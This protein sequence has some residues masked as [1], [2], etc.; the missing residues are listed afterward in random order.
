MAD[1]PSQ[2]AGAM[3]WTKSKRLGQAIV[4]EISIVNSFKETYRNREDITNLPP[5][6]LVVGSQNILSNVSE[7]LQTRQGYQI[8][9]SFLMYIATT[10]IS[11]NK[12]TLTSTVGVNTGDYVKVTFA[13]GITGLTS[14]SRYYVINASSTTLGFA[15]S[16]ANAI[17]GTYITI[18]GTPTG[19][20]IA[21]EK[22]SVNAPILSSFDW[23]SKGNSEIHMRAGFLDSSGSDG[24][25]QYRWVD[26]NSNVLWSDLLTGLTTVSYN[27]TTFW[28]TTEL[29][30]DCLF[31]NGTSNI[32]QWSGA[33]DTVTATTS[34]TIVVTTDINTRGWYNTANL[35]LLIRGVT[36]TYT[37]I[38]AKTFTGVSP[39]PT[40]GAN[41]VYA[42]DIAVQKVVTVAN[43][44][45]SGTNSPCPSSTFKNDL[46]SVLNNQIF[47]GS[48]SSP[49]I[50]MSKTN[51]FIDYGW[52]NAGIRVPAD[53]GTANL[54]DNT[55]GFI[56]QQDVMYVT[57]GKNFWY[58]TSLQQSSSYTGTVALTIETFTV[59]LLKTNPRQAAQSQGLINN[60]KNNVIMISNEPTF[61]VL[62]QLENIL[63]TPQ[64]TN[65]SDAIKLDFDTYNFANGHVFY[66]RYYL[67]VSVPMSGIIRMYSLV[68]KAWEAP[69]TIPATRFYTVNGNIYAHSYS[70]SESYQLFTGYSDRATSYGE[71]NPYLVT[72]NFSYQNF[73]TR[74]TLKNA[75]EFYIEGYITG[76]TNLSC[77]INYEEDGNLTTQTFNVL[78]DDTTIV[79]TQSASNSL[80]KTYYGSSGLGTYPSSSLTGL[81][82]KFRVIKTFPRFDF[83]ECQFS[84]SI[85]GTDQNFQLLAFGLN[86]A[87]SDTT[88]SA[89]KE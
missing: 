52:V 31:V 60:M 86:A 66:W 56:P 82:P 25:L 85:L 75:N 8:D 61:D 27:F 29:V 51:S 62:G 20:S 72:A 67:L 41:T 63:G 23:N 22:S 68:N 88:N 37:G 39:D 45:F 21:V 57:C 49:S 7:R 16:N 50:Y 74:T 14:G 59:K 70:S 81:P 36:Y 13:S 24:R 3:A 79:G 33:Y 44:A 34:N 80:G 64:T 43:S 15:T 11:A 71:G 78:G 17:A 84:F 65:I 32:F 38:T 10:A 12:V 87:P 53:G 42:G 4:K 83:Y 2:N 35:Q 47:L 5:G 1:S 9:G 19:A 89:I 18:S 73:G 30:R 46:I 55:V 26:A 6:V 77:L 28:N 40:S 76:N 48:L 54:D 69:Q 58:N